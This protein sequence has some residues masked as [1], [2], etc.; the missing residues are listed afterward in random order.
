MPSNLAP[1]LALETKQ[2]LCKQIVEDEVRS[3][4]TEISRIVSDDELRIKERTSGEEETV[5]EVSTAS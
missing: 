1:A 2:S 4:L 3:T 5:S